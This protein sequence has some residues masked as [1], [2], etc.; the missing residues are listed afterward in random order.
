M[1]PTQFWDYLMGYCFTVLYR[2][3]YAFRRSVAKK[4][5]LAAYTH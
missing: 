2:H 1:R 3:S 4:R 5:V